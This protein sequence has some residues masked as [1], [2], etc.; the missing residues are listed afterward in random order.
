MIEDRIDR[1]QFGRLAAGLLGAVAI[2]PSVALA[3]NTNNDATAIIR[4]LAPKKKQ[5]I[6]PN[7]SVPATPEQRPVVAT[8]D[9]GP[10]NVVV[11]PSASWDATIYFDYDSAEITT[12]AKAQLAA[13]GLALVSPELAAHSYLVGGHTD[14][15]GSADYNRDLSLRRAASV[16]RY[17]IQAFDISPKRLL[18]V[19]FGFDRLKTPEKP[20]SPANRRVEVALIVGATPAN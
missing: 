8:G 16:R 19:G 20:R 18:V 14:A 7:T 1:R 15:I 3:Q 5:D 13:L 2:A 11:D 12:K 9:A 4:S 17:L 6:R 10:V